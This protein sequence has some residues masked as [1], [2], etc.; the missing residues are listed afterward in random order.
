M[1]GEWGESSVRDREAE[2]AEEGVAE[3]D[4]LCSPRSTAA[5]ARAVSAPREVLAFDRWCRGDD[6]G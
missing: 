1:I 5:A 3:L 6:W 2:E 4:M